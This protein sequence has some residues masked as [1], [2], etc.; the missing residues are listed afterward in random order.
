[1]A[2]TKQ[3][4]LEEGGRQKRGLKEGPGG[5]WFSC[6]VGC[7]LLRREGTCLQTRQRLTLSTVLGLQGIKRRM[8]KF[9]ALLFA[10]H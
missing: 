5:V 8:K 1:M 7:G 3:T 2:T 10:A 9:S 4:P 6:S